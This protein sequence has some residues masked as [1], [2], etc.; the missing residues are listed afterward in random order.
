MSLADLVNVSITSDSV[1]VTAA[2]FGTPLILSHKA[3]SSA[4]VKYYTKAS[5]LLSD[6]FVAT[7]PE[8][9][10]AAVMMSA[11]TKVTQFGIGKCLL[12]PTQ[13]YKITLP[14]VTAGV[15]YEFRLGDEL[16]S[17]TAGTGTFATNDTIITQLAAAI[18]GATWYAAALFTVGTAGS[19]SATY[20]T[21]TAKTAGAWFAAESYAPDYVS[22]KQSHADPGIATDLAAIAAEDSTWYGLCGLSN[23]TAMI[24]AIAA[25]AESNEKLFVAQD[26]DGRTATDSL[27][28]AVA[29]AAAGDAATRAKTA[30]YARTA[31]IYHPASDAF[32]D[33]AWLGKCL[34]YEPGSETWAYKTLAGVAAVSLTSTHRTN[35]LAKYA[36]VYETVAGVS[37]TQFGTVAANEYLDVV[38][39]RDWLKARIAERIYGRLAGLKKLPFTDAGIAVVQAEI[40]GQLDEGVQV[41][42]LSPDPAP[43]CLVPL[44][45]A[46]STANKQARRLTGVTFTATLAG[47]IH[48]LV[49]EGVLSV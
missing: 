20:L 6:G 18:S 48:T 36:T 43:V 4:R 49:I 35:I 16:V 33:A 26:I 28:V 30:A 45:S 29:L 12:P 17:V 8:Y 2:G 38:R 32:A 47:A 21:V 23:S 1:G 42:G 10:A 40:L 44:A 37:V 24:L 3:A 41:G 7:D 14:T 22:I 25:W 9:L 11:S 39:F 34:P 13:Q 19:P 46:V 15:K 5:D 27:S 31:V